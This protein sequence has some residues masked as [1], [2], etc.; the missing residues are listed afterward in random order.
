[1]KLKKSLDEL[2]PKVNCEICGES[3]KE[4]LHRHHLIP[5]TDSNCTNHPFNLAVL[6]PNCHNLT[7]L[8]VIKIIGVF[9]STKASGRILIYVRDGVCNVPGM[10]DSEPY[11]KP[12]VELMKVRPDG[13]KT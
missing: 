3:N 11:Y 2:C 5:R 9:P 4:I 7:H 8:N 12:E 13:K 10:E 1:V 6:C